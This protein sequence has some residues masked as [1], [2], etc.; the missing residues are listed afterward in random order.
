MTIP[1]IREKLIRRPFI[2]KNRKDYK[3]WMKEE[4][5]GFLSD[6]ALSEVQSQIRFDNPPSRALVDRRR[7]SDVTPADVQALKSMS[8]SAR[9][10]PSVQR[11]IRWT[12]SNLEVL[13]D[14]VKYA[15]VRLRK[16]MKQ[17]W[18]S[19]DSWK[20]VYF[21]CSDPIA[22]GRSKKCLRIEQV[23]AWIAASSN[24]YVNVRILGPTLEYRRTVIYGRG[25]GGRKLSRWV[26]TKRA[27]G[28]LGPGKDRYTFRGK[29][30][31]LLDKNKTK[32]GAKKIKTNAVQIRTRM[33]GTSFGS[34]YQVKVGKAIHTAVAA[35][36]K[37][38]F[39]D[40]RI[41]YRFTRSREKLP[42]KDK[43]WERESMTGPN[44]HI[45]E[46]FIGILSPSGPVR[47]GTVGG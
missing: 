14:A 8:F 27:A 28:M 11:N 36:V 29:V 10:F 33:R 17:N 42:V 26:S 7:F 44:I 32:K 1:V 15:Y 43:K 20:S 12:F 23:K 46:L 47:G 37:R 39:K 25:T 24:Q 3:P 2:I 9:I 22:K 6:V 16:A 45:P 18:A 41:W 38:S 19:G 34:K 21:W 4:I 30:N 5:R 13:W 40:I 31:S 35:D